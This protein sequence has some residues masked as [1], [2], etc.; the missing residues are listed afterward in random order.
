[1]IEILRSEEGL[2]QKDYFSIENTLQESLLDVLEMTAPEPWR[3]FIRR[4]IPKL[5]DNA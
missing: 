4:R 2:F 1:M 5:S 3:V